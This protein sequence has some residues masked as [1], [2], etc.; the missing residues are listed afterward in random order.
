VAHRTDFDAMA[1]VPRTEGTR[2]ARV[3]AVEGPY[4]FYGKIVTS[5]AGRWEQLTGGRRAIVDPAL[6]TSLAASVG[7]TLV[8]G[9]GSFEIIAAIEDIPGAAGVES[10][11][12]PRVF[13]SGEFPTGPTCAW[14]TRPRPNR[15]R[16]NTAP[17]CGR[18]GSG[19]GPPSAIVRK[20]WKT[21]ISWAVTW[22]WWR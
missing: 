20:C 4:P 6:L 13:I 8:L 5:P 11:F 1:Y 3:N 2:F 22:A 7:D 21:W 19:S 10:A 16:T 12:S 14:P 18:T 9:E 17:C 15:S